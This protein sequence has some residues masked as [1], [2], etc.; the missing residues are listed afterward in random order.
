MI[1]LQVNKRIGEK[2]IAIVLKNKTSIG[3][4]KDVFT[5]KYLNSFKNLVLDQ[6]GCRPWHDYPS[7]LIFLF[8][9][10]EKQH[11]DP[12]RKRIAEHQKPGV[13]G[14]NFSKSYR[15]QMTLGRLQNGVRLAFLFFIF[16]ISVSVDEIHLY[17]NIHMNITLLI[18]KT[19]DI[20]GFFI[21][22]SYNLFVNLLQ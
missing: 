2:D 19:F 8:P 3:F 4:K 13:W 7:L 18:H 9:T 1:H 22:L 5:T 14:M 10:F 21:F 15:I 12:D 16:F 11:L 6:L 20:I 17:N